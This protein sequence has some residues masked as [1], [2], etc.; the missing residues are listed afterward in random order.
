MRTVITTYRGYE[1]VLKKDYSGDF[2]SIAQWGRR[3]TTGYVIVK[4]GCNAMPGAGWTE[5]VDKAKECIDIL[6]DIV[7]PQC[8]TERENREPGRYGDTFHAEYRRRKAAK[9]VAA[10]MA[11]HVAD[12]LN[13]LPLLRQTAYGEKLAALIAKIE[14]DC[15]TRPRVIHTDGSV[16]RID[17]EKYA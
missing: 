4:D 15:D 17:G 7:I 9:T 14:D 11:L 6:E 10:E 12:L 3:I 16:T 5:T 8:G 2:I 1:I 13:D